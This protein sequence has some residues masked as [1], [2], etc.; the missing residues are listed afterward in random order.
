MP[1]GARPS[2]VVPGACRWPWP[3]GSRPIRRKV[4]RFRPSAT[5]STIEG[6]SPQRG[7]R[8]RRVYTDFFLLTRG[9][10]LLEPRG[11]CLL[12]PRLGG[13]MVQQPLTHRA[14]AGIPLRALSPAAVCTP[15]SPPDSMT[16]RLC[17]GTG[18]TREPGV[19]PGRA[20]RTSHLA[21]TGHQGTRPG[22]RPAGELTRR[23]LGRGARRSAHVTLPDA[24][25]RAGTRGPTQSCSEPPTRCSGSRVPRWKR[26]G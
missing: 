4:A 17:P 19:S 3:H 9:E 20:G 8:E 5:S 7:E 18:T 25:G 21:R 12:G 11:P 23:R 1:P 10:T 16:R 13:D 22:R 24:R 6:R 14:P 15:G 2:C 26:N